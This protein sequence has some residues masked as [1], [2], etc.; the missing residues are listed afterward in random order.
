MPKHGKLVHGHETLV[1][2]VDSLVGDETCCGDHVCCHAVANEKNNI[3]RFSDL[4][5]VAD[6]PCCLGCSSIVVCQCSG[7]LWERLV[8][9]IYNVFSSYLLV[10]TKQPCGK[11]LL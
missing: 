6:Q 1:F 5:K 2:S 10:H 8:D 3:L 4:C 9:I 11:P 7:V